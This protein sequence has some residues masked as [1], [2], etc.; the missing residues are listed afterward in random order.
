M[1]IPA[2][3][4]PFKPAATWAPVVCIPLP[5]SSCCHVLNPAPPTP[6]TVPFPL[7]NPCPNSP[8]TLVSPDGGVYVTGCG[9]DCLNRRTNTLCDPK[10]CPC[11]EACTNQPFHMRGVPPAVAFLTRDRGYGVRAT[12]RLPA[13]S[14]LVE[15]AGEVSWWWRVGGTGCVGCVSGVY[16]GGVMGVGGWWNMRGR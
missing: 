2:C 11:G 4:N 16:W 13:R 8:E 6:H 5:S 3:K 15:Y 12:R 7:P 9:E 1:S 14:F 10:T